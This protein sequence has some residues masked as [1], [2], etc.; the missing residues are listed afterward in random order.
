M[1]LKV[2]L[3]LNGN[4]NNQGLSSASINSN[5]NFT[6]ENGK[7]GKAVAFN[8]STKYISIDKFDTPE[9]SI[10]AWIYLYDT[11][12]TKSI[13]LSQSSSGTDGLSIYVNTDGKCSFQYG[14]SIISSEALN[15]NTWYHITAVLGI[16]RGA[17]L[18]IDGSLIATGDYIKPSYDNVEE[19]VI[20][21]MSTSS[22]SNPFMG[23]IN[24]IRVYD[25]ALSAKKVK[26]LSMG[27]VAHYPLNHAGLDRANLVDTGIG[28]TAV[29]GTIATSVNGVCIDY[30]KSTETPS[31]YVPVVEN[32]TAGTYTIAFDVEG[33]A[34]TDNITL[35]FSDGTS[36]VIENGR[37]IAQ[38]NLKTTVNSS[39]GL[40]VT[41]KGTTTSTV[42]ITRFKL[43]PG[44]EST[45]YIP[46][47]TDPVYSKLGFDSTAVTNCAGYGNHAQFVGGLPTPIAD[48]GRNIG[49]YQFSSGVSL[50]IPDLELSEYTVCYWSNSGTGWKFNKLNSLPSVL[51]GSDIALSDIRVYA[52]ILSDKD[53]SDLQ[54]VAISIDNGNYIHAFAYRE[55]DNVGIDSKGVLSNIEFN[56]VNDIVKIYDSQVTSREFYEI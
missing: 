16:A 6:Y 49:S 10:S 3:P 31:F 42:L 23:L 47:S 45:S 29:T 2:W 26:F 36:K 8:N 51:G 30:S 17:E 27:L 33:L 54:N 5:G 50:S 13:I 53:L 25:N 28:F 48:S 38:L 9:I 24:D 11:P 1:S 37:N 39:T 19:L 15:S 20:G 35:T 43:E 21:K 14:S 12:I 4:L 52:T 7:L 18:Y 46:S 44:T 32:I 22:E 34:D 41:A 56:E 40:L 55:S